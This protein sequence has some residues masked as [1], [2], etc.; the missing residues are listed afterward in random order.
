MAA[1]TVHHAQL[2]SNNLASFQADF[3]NSLDPYLQYEKGHVL[4]ND[5]YSF[6]SS[7]QTGSFGKVTLAA[8]VTSNQPVAIKALKKSVSGVRSMANHEVGIMKHLGY[9]P[10]ICQLVDKFETK[11]YIIL[12]LEYIECG[13]LYDAVHNKTNLGMAFQS[14][15]KMFAS[16]CQQLYNVVK[17]THSKGV[18]HRD[19]KPEN[20]LLTTDGTI[21]LCDWGLATRNEEC[22][23]FN[24]GTEK[25]MAPEALGDHKEDEFYDATKVDTWS[26][27]IT[28]LYTLFNKCPFRKALPMDPNYAAFLQD[29][30]FLFSFYQNSTVTCYNGI[31][32]KLLLERDLDGGL[33][34]LIINGPLR[35]FNIDQEYN[36]S[37]TSQSDSTNFVESFENFTAEELD[38]E[39]FMFD[40]EQQ[41]QKLEMKLDYENQG[42]VQLPVSQTFDDSQYF[43]NANVLPISIPSAAMA[44]VG[45]APTTA[46]ASFSLNA[47]NSLFDKNPSFMNSFNPV[48]GGSWYD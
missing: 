41:Q 46:A 6:L 27:G 47:G 29:K 12:V 14:N 32:D 30:N 7:L 5:R 36:I 40:D 23:D 11:K 2:F 34:Y 8:D 16:L 21:K 13:D 24:V 25:Y 38:G 37:F 1:S 15:A 20:I 3:K 28:L 4:L 33:N 18:Y 48:A 44:A 22:N 26:I 31:V 10:N 42:Q 45:T 43:D 19:I 35:G 17:Y 39:M 9:H